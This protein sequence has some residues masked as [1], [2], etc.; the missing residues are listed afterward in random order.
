M[1]YRSLFSGLR[2]CGMV[3]SAK[4]N[5]HVAECGEHYVLLS[6]GKGTNGNFTV[7]ARKGVDYMVK[8][9]G[10]KR[11]VTS[12]EAFA[13]CK[14][15]RFLTERF[16]ILNALYVLVGTN[17]ARISKMAGQTLYFDIRKHAG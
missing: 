16:A 5:Y 10:G 12:A 1:N 8:R 17:R 6:P 13:A 9:L 4:R 3:R 7:V 15:S 14:R 2:Y 11:G